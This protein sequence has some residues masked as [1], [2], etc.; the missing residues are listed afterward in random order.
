MFIIETKI[1]SEFCQIDDILQFEN[2]LCVIQRHLSDPVL[3][4]RIIPIWNSVNDPKEI[5]IK[6][7]EHILSFFK[8]FFWI[9]INYST[10][11]CDGL[12]YK[13]PEGDFLT[14]GSYS[15]SL[16]CIMTVPKISHIHSD[17]VKIGVNEKTFF[18]K[19]KLFCENFSVISKYLNVEVEIGLE[20]ILEVFEKHPNRLCKIY[21][22]ESNPLCIEIHGYGRYYIAPIMDEE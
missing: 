10:L 20:Y 19:D 13:F 11:E 14:W 12:T 22:K 6:I 7:D 8:N 17:I 15:P 16:S 3:E 2:N 4:E 5:T 9:K 21:I 18:V 1:F